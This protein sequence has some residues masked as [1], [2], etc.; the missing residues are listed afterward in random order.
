[1]GSLYYLWLILIVKI[2]EM[3]SMENISN[4]TKN[5]VQVSLFFR[6]NQLV[7]GRDF[8]IIKLYSVHYV[9]IHYD[10]AFGLGVRKK[11]DHVLTNVPRIFR[12][13]CGT[14]YKAIALN[15]YG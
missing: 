15:F 3:E 10:N 14:K 1:M 12:P 5:R 9:I 4:R 6:K 13:L 7:A 11:V 8:Y 2:Q